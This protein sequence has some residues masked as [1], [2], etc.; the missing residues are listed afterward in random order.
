[1]KRFS[2]A[3]FTGILA[4][5]L[6]TSA[7]A[8]QGTCQGTKACSQRLICPNNQ[9]CPNSQ[10]CPNVPPKDGT[11]KQKGKIKKTSQVCPNVP[12]KDGTGSQRRGK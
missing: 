5:G 4:I 7:F 10:V 6:V 2:T 8:A 1:M 12:L 11:G 3:V 9:V